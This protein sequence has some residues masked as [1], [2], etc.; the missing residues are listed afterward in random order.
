MEWNGAQ[1]CHIWTFPS[2]VI[3]KLR[4][5]AIHRRNARHCNTYW[6]MLAAVVVVRL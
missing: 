2:A 4:V 6:S 5:S 1:V 3:G